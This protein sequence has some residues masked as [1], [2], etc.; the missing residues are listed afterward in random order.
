MAGKRLSDNNQVELNG[1]GFQAT[2]AFVICNENE[3]RKLLVIDLLKALANGT[4]LDGGFTFATSEQLKEFTSPN[5]GRYK[6]ENGEIKQKNQDDNGWYTIAVAKSGGKTLNWGNLFAVSV[7]K[8]GEIEYP[9]NFVQANNLVTSDGGQ[10]KYLKSGSGIIGD[11]FNGSTSPTWCIDDEYVRQIAQQTRLIRAD[12]G[13]LVE[14]KCRIVNG[15]PQF[16]GKVV[17]DEQ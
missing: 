6:I 17:D 13:E 9:T 7:N 14:I 12:S 4:N 3:D 11:P 1:S 5:G 10:L 16:Y 15:V 2:D 8:D